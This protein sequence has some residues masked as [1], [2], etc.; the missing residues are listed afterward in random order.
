MI[1]DLYLSLWQSTLKDKNVAL[2]LKGLN[3]DFVGST[4][5]RNICLILLTIYRF[6]SVSV[7]IDRDLGALL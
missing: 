5:T 7:C 4:N 2:A 1:S 3:T 6:I